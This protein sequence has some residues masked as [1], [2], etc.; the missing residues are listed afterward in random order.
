MLDHLWL[1][2]STT[3]VFLMQVGFLCLESGRTRSK[4][5]INVAA[6]NVT[7]FIVSACVFWL[8]GFGLMF[9]PSIGGWVGI[10]EF[11]FGQNNTPY[12]ILFF[13]FQMMFCSTAATLMSG[14]VAERMRF[15]GYIY[16]TIILSAFIYPL[17]G[18]WAWASAFN[19]DNQGW[20]EKLGFIDFAGSTVVHSVGGWVALAAVL[21]IGPRLGRF[22]SAHSF[23]SG[24][25][26]PI[27]ALGTMLIWFGWFGFNGGSALI[28][29]DLVPI[30]IL[31]TCLAGIWG[32]LASTVLHQI[33]QRYVDVAS[34]LNG[35]IAGLVGVTAGCH[36]V[37]PSEAAFIGVVAG[38]I[39]N[40]GSQLLDQLEIDDALKVIPTHL[41]AGIW[42]TLAVGLFGDP[43]ILGT[44]LSMMQQLLVQLMGI[45]TIGVFSFFVSYLLI[46]LI[47]RSHPLR[48]SEGDEV[49]GLNISEH[50]AT[51]ELIES[52]I[53]LTPTLINHQ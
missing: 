14:A 2:I 40:Y 19:S 51:T 15:S 5:N 43:N 27:A 53:M 52:P 22:Q 38:V 37:S 21:V 11:L 10:G 13:L 36:A 39:V 32:G 3:F 6:K 30:I 31:N 23:P 26:L 42:G 17:V 28:F 34:S 4:N 33:T 44:G 49:K 29:D 7:D 9:G 1:L 25:N 18:H 41:F 48:V 20:L 24:S 46:V 16:I 50:H 8:F 35:I 45:V 12:Q 47:N